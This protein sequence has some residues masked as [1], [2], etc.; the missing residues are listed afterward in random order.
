MTTKGS[1][2]PG[3]SAPLC[4]LEPGQAGRSRRSGRSR[5]GNARISPTSLPDSPA[6]YP[7]RDIVDAGF[8]QL[9]RYGILAA[10]DPLIVDSLRVVDAILKIDTPQGPAGIATTTT[11]TDNGLTAVRS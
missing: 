2:V 1:L 6:S 7:A 8:L 5:R 11:A 3:V 9:V 10:D 4:A